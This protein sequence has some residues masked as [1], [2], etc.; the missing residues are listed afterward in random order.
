MKNARELTDDVKREVVSGLA[1]LAT[2]RDE[3]KLHLH[4]ATMEAKQEWD[5]KL[6]PR[7]DELQRSASD[8][9]DESREAIGELVSKVE[10]FVSRLRGKGSDDEAAAS[11]PS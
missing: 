2:L 5:E 11:R 8:L 7:I 1:T 10:G 4:L 6:E 9:K 3:A